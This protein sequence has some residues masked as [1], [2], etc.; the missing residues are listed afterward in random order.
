MHGMYMYTYTSACAHMCARMHV[1]V[2]AHVLACVCKRICA[3]LV[4]GRGGGETF[5]L[6]LN[7]KSIH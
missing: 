7:P 3:D 6:Q 2:P 5:L 4:G 1:C